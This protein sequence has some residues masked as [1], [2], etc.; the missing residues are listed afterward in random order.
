KEMRDLS[1]LKALSVRKAT[2][3]RGVYRDPKVILETR[4]HK[5]L[6]DPK[7]QKVL[8]GLKGIRVNVGRKDYRVQNLNF[9]RTILLRIP[10][11]KLSSK[12]R[13]FLKL[14][15]TL[16][17]LREMRT[18]NCLLRMRRFP[19]LTLILRDLRS[20]KEES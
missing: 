1:V 10:K 15:S 4:V 17:S 16:T 13:F 20:T 7:D 6:P 5:V 8:R 2:R 12:R 11:G 18:T 19:K 14:T 9:I 3:E